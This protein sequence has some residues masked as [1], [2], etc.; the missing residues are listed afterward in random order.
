MLQHNA[1]RGDPMLLGATTPP[2]K[3]QTVTSVDELIEKSL[4]PGS[5]V[6]LEVGSARTVP[7]AVPTTV[8]TTVPT[9]GPHPGGKSNKYEKLAYGTNGCPAGLEIKSPSECWTAVQSL[10]SKAPTPW[11][12]GYA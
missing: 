2:F 9:N 10:T 7:T 1:K 12:G 6:A 11:I 5:I 3:A 4:V 8:P